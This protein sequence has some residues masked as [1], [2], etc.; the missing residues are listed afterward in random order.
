MFAGGDDQLWPAD[1]AARE[2][3]DRILVER[4]AGW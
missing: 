4:L 1:D 2:A 3:S